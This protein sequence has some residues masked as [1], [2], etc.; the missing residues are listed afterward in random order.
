MDTKDPQLTTAAD[1]TRKEEATSSD[2]L[3]DLEQTEQVSTNSEGA[4]N[5]SDDTNAVTAPDGASDPAR[6]DNSDGRDTGGPM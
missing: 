5:D 4:A 6:G 3:A 1:D 2:T